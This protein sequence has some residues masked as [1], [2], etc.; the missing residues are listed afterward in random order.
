MGFIDYR[1]RRLLEE[2]ELEL[3]QGTLTT[4][5]LKETQL[6]TLGYKEPAASDIMLALSGISVDNSSPQEL[7]YRIKKAQRILNLHANYD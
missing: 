2:N 4:Q 5:K 7:K 6:E 3:S 1:L